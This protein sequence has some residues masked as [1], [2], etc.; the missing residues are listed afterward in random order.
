MPQLN[1]EEW[2]A[3]LADCPEAHILQSAPWGELKKTFGW[4]VVYW[5]SQA[6]GE[7]IGAQILFRRLPLGY[8]F[9]YIP[10]GP[11]GIGTGSADAVLTSPAMKK[12]LAEVDVL[13]RQR[14]SIFL[15]IEPDI[16]LSGVHEE[17]QVVPSGFNLSQHSI[18][19]LRTI[20]LDIGVS[21]EEVL[22]RMKQK[23]RYNIRLAEK[24]GVQ[25][26]RTD[27]LETFYDLMQETGKRDRFGVH[28]Q[29]YYRRA[30]EL[31]RPLGACELFIAEYKGRALAA[32]MVFAW[33]QRAWYFY[34]ASSSEHRELMPAYLVQ[35]EA[36]RW[37]KSKG[38]LQYDLWGVPDV[39]EELLER[40]FPHRDDGL[41]G[42]Y[43]FK[44]GFGGKVCRAAGPWDRVYNSFL[45]GFYRLWAWRDGN[46]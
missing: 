8:R 13:C 41:W 42:V 39:P 29:D 36:I 12:F 6:H 21:L 32:I 4:E 16:L 34:G 2:H 45:Y 26:R 22:A 14:K 18:Q 17:Q 19:P 10:K 20:V 28:S 37:A 23:T 30:Y 40:M 27:S 9:A 35:W 31:F 43:R 7:R 11:V 3:F 24:K 1:T 46:L 15:K 38:C 33:G 44:R 5:V 25:V